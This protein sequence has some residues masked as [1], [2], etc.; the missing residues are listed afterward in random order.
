[1][2]D[3]EHITHIDITPTPEGLQRVKA[4]F[5]QQQRESHTILEKIEFFR[6]GIEFEP[7]HAIPL[8]LLRQLPLIS[9]AIDAYEAQERK[10]IADMQEG[11]DSLGEGEVQDER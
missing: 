6:T 5:L 4:I 11:L 8:F 2:S 3:Q 9:E 1:M 7:D 10:R